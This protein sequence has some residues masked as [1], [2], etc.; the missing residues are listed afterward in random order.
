MNDS[1]SDRTH[2]GFIA[3]QMRDALTE[4]RLGSQELAALV[5]KDYDAETEGGGD[6]YYSIRSSELIALNTA[7]VQA[8]MNRVDAL[9]QRLAAAE[10]SV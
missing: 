2:T 6:G 1:R 5:Q 4:S 10:E 8:L 3:Q 7:M 9:E